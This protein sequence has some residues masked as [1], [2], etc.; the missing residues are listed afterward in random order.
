MVYLRSSVERLI[1]R[2]RSIRLR[3]DT[4]RSRYRVVNCLSTEFRYCVRSCYRVVNCFIDG[5]PVWELRFMYYGT[6]CGYYGILPECVTHVTSRLEWRDLR[7]SSSDVCGGPVYIGT[8]FDNADW[9][10]WHNSITR[11]VL[12]YFSFGIIES[13]RLVTCLY[14]SFLQHNNI[15]NHSFNNQLKNPKKKEKKKVQ[16]CGTHGDS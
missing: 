15:Y 16:K 7:T 4:V 6:G 14:V 11:I 5:V 3:G 2:G 13:I 10:G 8:H 12:F 1:D 9:S